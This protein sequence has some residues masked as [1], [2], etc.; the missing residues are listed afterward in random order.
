VVQQAQGKQL[1][2]K[3]EIKLLQEVKDIRDE[4]NMLSN[5]L[6]DQKELISKLSRYIVADVE[7]ESKLEWGTTGRCERITRMDRDADRVERSVCNTLPP[8]NKRRAC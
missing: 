6:S 3:E 8:Y 1:E 5:V 2:I 7:S 4:L